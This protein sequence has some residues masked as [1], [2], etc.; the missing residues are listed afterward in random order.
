MGLNRI[1]KGSVCSVSVLV[2]TFGWFHGFIRLCCFYNQMFWLLKCQSSN[3]INMFCRSVAVV[4]VTHPAGIAL[5]HTQYS[6]T[7][8]ELW[9]SSLTIVVFHFQN[10]P[11]LRPTIQ[12]KGLQG[13]SICLYGDFSLLNLLKHKYLISYNQEKPLIL[14][15]LVLVNHLLKCFSFTLF[16]VTIVAWSREVVKHTWAKMCV[17]TWKEL[18]LLWSG[19]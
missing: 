2:K 1:C 17:G 12:F 5:T 16:Y 15:Q 9:C 10:V 6:F 18:Q 3:C 11:S 13:V 4:C 19:Y 8:T 14:F 7:F